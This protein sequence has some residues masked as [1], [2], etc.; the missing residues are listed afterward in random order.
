[1]KSGKFQR[2]YRAL[3]GCTKHTFKLIFLNST[4]DFSA[5][6]NKDGPLGTR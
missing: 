6:E 3:N 2:I 1:M 4:C 5:F